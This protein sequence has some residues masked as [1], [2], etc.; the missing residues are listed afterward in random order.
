MT[1]NEP[2]KAPA[3]SARRSARLRWSGFVVLAAGLIGAGTV[4]WLG[5]RSPDVR[6][7]LSMVGYNR[8]ER[9]QMGQLYGRMG[10]FIEDWSEDL[11]RPGNQA[12]LILGASI[13][14]AA[15]CFYLGRLTGYEDRNH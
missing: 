9:R 2:P 4:Y 5:T 15:G 13:L 12:A 8:A 6:D 1:A 11:K 7:D 14:V 3:A 10:T